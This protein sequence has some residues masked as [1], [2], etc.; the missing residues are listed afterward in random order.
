MT[1]YTIPPVRSALLHRSH[2]HEILDLSR[3]VPLT[4]LSAPA[5]FGKTT[6]LSTW[7]SQSVGAVAWLA[8][9]EQ[10]NDPTRFWAYVIAAL[11][12]A[13]APAGETVN[14]LLRSPSLSLLTSALTSLINE[15]AALEQDIALILDD[16]HLIHEQAIHDSLQ[17]VL[18]HLPLDL[19]LLLASRVDPAFP[20]ARLRA[21]AQVIEI[22]EADLRLRDEEAARFLT[23]V[24]KLTLAEEEI[25]RLQTRTEGWI[26]G[27]QLAGLSLRRHTN[28]AAFLQAFTGSHRYILDY[29]QEEI[30]QP[31]PEE[32]QRFLLYTS[33][34]TR[35]NSAICQALTGELAS[36]Q[37]LEDLERTNLFLIPLDEERCWYRFHALFREVLLARLEATQ[38]EQ[39]S[40]LHREAALWYVRQGG[41]HEAIPHALAT[42]DFLFVAELLEGCVDRLS[43]QGELNTLLMWIKQL[44]LEVL[45]L[46]PHLVTTYLLVF[47]MLFPFTQQEQEER[48]YLD[49]L[50]D[51]MELLL[52]GDDHGELSV[53]ERDRLRQRMVVLDTWRLAKKALSAGDM[54]QL[55]KVAEQLQPPELDDDALWRQHGLAP[56]AMAWRMAGNF[57]PLVGAIQSLL[58]RTRLAQ[59]RAQEPHI[60]WGL[61]AALIALGQLR[62]ARNCC[63][64]LQQLIDS[65]SVPAPL[66]AYP[67]LFQ[68]QLAYAWNNLDLAQ[69]AAR[70]AIDRVAPLQYMDIL[71]GAYEVLVRISII[72]G[73][74]V[75]AEQS[76]GE[77]EQVNQSV[78]IPLFRPWIES[79]R[80]HLWLAQGNL[81]RAVDWAERSSYRQ[82]VFAYSVYSRET[83]YLALVRVSLAQQKY[84]Q[85]LHLLKAL[86]SS[87]ERV[88][89]AG[90]IVSILAL[91]VATLQASGATDEALRDLPRLLALAAPEGYLRAFLDAGEPMRQTLQQYLTTS[92]HGGSPLLTSYAQT[93][94][95]A[96]AHEQR[97][98][99]TEGAISPGAK[100]LQRAS[101]QAVQQ[102]ITPLTSRELEVLHLLAEGAS[103][104][105]IASQLVVQLSTAKKHVASI[106]SKLGA[107]NRTQAI[108]RARALSLL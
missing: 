32:Q 2:L 84:P 26:T 1:K 92:Q 88:S 50:H 106:L 103:N 93:V 79:L 80:V 101:P 75:G 22:R 87:A 13:G 83:A 90:S 66:A 57:P 24:M 23:Q 38:P 105:E 15:L 35:I 73:D 11:R 37:M 48:L 64:D 74:L 65:L 14:V 61:V 59:D 99:V 43:V 77:M 63:Q 36:Q 20:L 17:F 104:R 9:D 60:L 72:R 52:Q 16:Y 3:S 68:A 28:T 58:Q 76:L 42:R 25:G 94:L 51:G 49:Q 81:A 100:A 96:F 54:E 44:P 47:N 41:L 98:D 91:Q 6:L 7:A 10:D 70:K 55:S 30:L 97:R 78:D 31:L 29:V 102:L 85:A 18:D 21:R 56:F 69:N 46:H 33:V 12:K 8:L 45:S 82:E 95:D 53:G 71:M 107:E 27:L 86:L 40:R 39:V 89:R 67:D 62:E 108:A 5:G 19:H 4:L 34:L